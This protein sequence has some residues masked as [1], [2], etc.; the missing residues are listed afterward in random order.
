MPTI[1]ETITKQAHENK[2]KDAGGEVIVPH[3]IINILEKKYESKKGLGY[4]C[5]VYLEEY[6]K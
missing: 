3:R 4:L 1:E 2:R 5:G 6:L